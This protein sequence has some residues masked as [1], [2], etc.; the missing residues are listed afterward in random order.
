MSDWSSIRPVL[1][2][3]VFLASCGDPQ[4]PPPPDPQLEEAP[5]PAAVAAPGGGEAHSAVG[6]QA[7]EGDPSTFAPADAADYARGP[8]IRGTVRH[9]EGLA[10]LSGFTVQEFG[11]EGAEAVIS[12]EKGG[13]KFTLKNEAMPA[14]LVQREGWIDTIQICSE[15]SREYFEGEYKIEVFEESDTQIELEETGTPFDPSK[16]R[17]VLNFQPLGAPAG[18]LAELQAPDGKPWT[19]DAKDQQNPG[20]RIGTPPG[21][22]EV[23]YS[24]VSPGTW[25]VRVE[26]PPPLECVGP[27]RVPVVAATYTRAY[28][29]CLTPEQ[30]AAAKARAGEQPASTD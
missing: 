13:F 2:L 17:V 12:G 15:A 29:F 7:P 6:H 4:P 18:V 10:E 24:N 28:Y 23:V 22:G 20:N 3:G 19:Y 9:G 21:I 27:E 1:A 30:R 11:V 8:V 5:A 14:V 25:P 16:G 26:A